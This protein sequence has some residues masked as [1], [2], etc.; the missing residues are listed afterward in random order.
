MKTIRVTGIALSIAALLLV[1]MAPPASAECPQ[2][3]GKYAFRLVGGK[4]FAADLANSAVVGDPAN[5]SGVTTT[6][7]GAGRQ[8]VVVVGT[9]S[10]TGSTGSIING[11][12]VA[13]TDGG[14]ATF[15]GGPGT[16][17][18]TW[19]D[20]ETVQFGFTGHFQCIGDLTGTLTINPAVYNGGT[21]WV[22]TDTTKSPPTTPACGGTELNL[23][24]APNSNASCTGSGAP[25][26][27]CTAAG[28]G[29]CNGMTFSIGVSQSNGRVEL[30]ETDNGLPHANTDTSTTKIFLSGEA[31]KE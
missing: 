31:V 10:A 8:S 21:P 30:A 19:S 5:I 17:P 15:V 12:A 20:T 26:A 22:C 2:L 25:N 27:C 29:T 6:Q 16:L 24:P 3:N 9:F 13:T 4:S 11:D 23:S 1:A 7:P 18:A 28:A 14:V